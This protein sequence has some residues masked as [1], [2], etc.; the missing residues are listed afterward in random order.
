MILKK[1]LTLKEGNCTQKISLKEVDLIYSE[2]G[3]L[4]ARQERKL[5]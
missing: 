1:D 3:S 5:S 2:G 4:T